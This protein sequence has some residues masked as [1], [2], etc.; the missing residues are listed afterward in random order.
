MAPK[1]SLRQRVAASARAA[2]SQDRGPDEPEQG[3]EPEGQNKDSDKKM[4]NTGVRKR[5]RSAASSSSCAGDNSMLQLLR[6]RWSTGDLSSSDVQQFAAAAEESGAAGLGQFQRIGGGGRHPGNAQRDLMRALG[7]PRGSPEFYTSVI[8]VALAN[9]QASVSHHPFVLPHALFSS[10]YAAR[11]ETFQKCVQGDRQER[12]ELWDTLSQHPVVQN[13][14]VLRSGELKHVIPVGLHGDAGAFSNND[15]LYVITWNSLVGQGTTR[16]QRFIITVIRKREMLQD[17][18]TLEALFRVIAWSL[19]ALLTGFAPTHD[20][21]GLPLPD[22]GH[23]LAGPWRGA[24]VQIRGDWQWYNQAFAVP[25]WNALGRMCFLCCA[26]NADKE[27]LWTNFNPSAPWRDTLWTHEAYLAHLQASGIDVPNIFSIHGLRVECLMVDV[28]HAVDLGIAS[29][30]IGNILFEV[31]PS[32]GANRDKQLLDLNNRLQVWYRRHGVESR[33]PG[34]LTMQTI[35]AQGKWPELKAK[36]AATRHL[37]PFAAELASEFN[38]GSEH[39]RHRQSV[40]E[41]LVTFYRLVQQGSRHIAPSDLGQLP[42]LC[43]TLCC[44]YAHLAHEAIQSGTQA[45]KLKPKM[46]LFQHLCHTQAHEFGN[47]RFYWTYAD[48]DMVGQMIEVA[49][50]CHPS[51][52]A[53][54]ALYKY[55]VMVFAD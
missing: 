1:W 37:A 23:E 15:S 31:L 20:E 39:D 18:S 30:I 32:L 27:L 33:I 34:R 8:P 41:S 49:R 48:E 43:Q 40:I 45:W 46:H 53:K 35:R 17:G 4:P 50:S 38:S 16:E 7:K 28:L 24:C 6:E 21:D 19:N 54:T 36:A 51:T 26:S 52:L 29:D 10:L 11:V 55:L 13:H 5:L 25:Q 47:P 42:N 3:Q 12:Q 14:P 44:A 22:G 2:S 9:G